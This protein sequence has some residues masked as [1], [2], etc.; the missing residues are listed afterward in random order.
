MAQSLMLE[1]VDAGGAADSRAGILK[2]EFRVP[3]RNWRAR[4]VAGFF[5]LLL[6]RPGDLGERSG[7]PL[8]GNE[9]AGVRSVDL[10]RAGFSGLPGHRRG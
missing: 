7:K 1:F 9:R 4:F 2:R 5:P 6:L 3:G 10:S 8:L